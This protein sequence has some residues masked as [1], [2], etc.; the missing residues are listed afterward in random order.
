MF[1]LG[2]GGAHC[3]GQALRRR[4]PW[5]SRAPRGSTPARVIAD[6]RELARAHRRRARRPA[7][8]VDA[9]LGAARDFLRELL[10]E[11]GLEPDADGPATSGRR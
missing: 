4:A 9:D 6:L 5:L 1:T 2:G 3:L 7:L 10:G 8:C 11:I